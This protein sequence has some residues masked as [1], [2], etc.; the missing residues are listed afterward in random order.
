MNS[1]MTNSFTSARLCF[2]LLPIFSIKLAAAPCP[3]CNPAALWIVDLSSTKAA[4]RC[5]DP[6]H[7]LPAVELKQPSTQH[8]FDQVRLAISCWCIHHKIAIGIRCGHIARWLH[9]RL[10]LVL[11][12]TSDALVGDVATVHCFL[13]MGFRFTTVQYTSI[14]KKTC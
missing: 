13:L 5:N 2:C 6:H 10:R 1:S 8:V 9:F 14:I 11:Y 3:L 12:V 4:C 7:D